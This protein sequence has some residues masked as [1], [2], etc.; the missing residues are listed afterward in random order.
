M[1]MLK[2]KL[3]VSSAVVG[4]IYG[5]SRKK[6]SLMVIL[7]FTVFFYTIGNILGDSIELYKCRKKTI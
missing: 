7:G 2:E 6:T 3:A 5:L 1:L 4:L